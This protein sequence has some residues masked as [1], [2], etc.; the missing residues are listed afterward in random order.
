MCEQHKYALILILKFLLSDRG[1]DKHEDIIF[2]SSYAN[3]KRSSIAPAAHNSVTAGW[4]TQ[5]KDQSGCGACVA[6]ATASVVE[7]CMLKAGSTLKKET[8]DLSEQ[9]LVDCGMGKL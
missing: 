2:S 6:F 4:V 1:G 8:M 5:P 3:L 9:T 7:T